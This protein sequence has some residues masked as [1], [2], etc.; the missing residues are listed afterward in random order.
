MEF[1]YRLPEEIRVKIVG[2]IRIDLKEEIEE[3]GCRILEYTHEYDNIVNN[4]HDRCNCFNGRL[5]YQ[6][7]LIEE[8]KEVKSSFVARVQ[9]RV[10]NYEQLLRDLG[11]ADGMI[12]FRRNVM[13]RDGIEGRYEDF[14][15][16]FVR[17]GVLVYD[18]VLTEFKDKKEK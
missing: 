13:I 8:V 16:S 15:I 2:Q 12:R 5:F 1:F 17:T 11:V 14:D 18:S 3:K 7:A 10:A 4:M 6:R 9:R